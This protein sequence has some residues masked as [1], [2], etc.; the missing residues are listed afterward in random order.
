MAEKLLP[1][2]SEVLNRPSGKETSQETRSRIGALVAELR[3]RAPEVQPESGEKA[4][5]KSDRDEAP[6]PGSLPAPE[7][8]RLQPGA[9]PVEQAR[10]L[11][12]RERKAQGLLGEVKFWEHLHRLYGR[13]LTG[14]SVDSELSLMLVENY[15]RVHWLPNPLHVQ[16]DQEPSMQRFRRAVVMVGRLDGP[17]PR[18]ARRLVDD[19]LKTE[20]RGFQGICY[21][22]A[23][24]LKGKSEVGSYTWFDHHLERLAEL[25]KQHSTLKVVLDLRSGLFL[26]GSCPRAA[27]YCGW[28][29]LAKYVASCTWEPGAVAYHV[30]SAE[31]T[32]LRSPGSQV[33]CKRLLEEG[34]AATL[35]PVAEPYLGA[36]PLPDEFFPLLMKGDL[37]LLEVYYRTVPHLSW[38]MILIGDPLYRPFKKDPAWRSQTTL[39]DGPSAV[40]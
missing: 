8:S 34:V 12:A 36:F 31:A 39:P 3:G 10:Q 32:T 6:L 24:G 16:F 4:N 7:P 28:Y 21:L 17:T 26:R 11:S 30:A 20:S 29:S 18:I 2:A 1:R 40:G 33:W 13:P 35:G 19:A 22:D 23:R 5:G 27:L 14:A 9:G 38:Q 37:S 25:M 15:P